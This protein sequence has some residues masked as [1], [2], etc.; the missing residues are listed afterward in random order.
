MPRCEIDVDACPKFLP[1][2]NRLRKK[3]FPKIQ[4][5]LNAVFEEIEKDYT[6]AAGAAA[7]PGWEGKVWKHRCGSSDTKTGRRGGFRIISQVDTSFEPHRLYA[8]LIYAKTEKDDV[9]VIEVADAVKALQ[10]EL[11]LLK[12]GLE[13]GPLSEAEPEADTTME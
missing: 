1:L 6:T 8:M 10:Q 9:T 3:K 4:Q 12:R 2:V 5:D 11:E 13:A 7:I